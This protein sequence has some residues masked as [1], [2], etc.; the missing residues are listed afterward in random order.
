M[1]PRSRISGVSLKYLV[2]VNLQV[3]LSRTLKYLDK[4]KQLELVMRYFLVDKTRIFPSR[5]KTNEISLIESIR[6]SNAEKTK[7][8][9]P[10]IQ[11]IQSSD[12]FVFRVSHLIKPLL[13]YNTGTISI[14]LK[15]WNICS[16]SIKY[17]I[18]WIWIYNWITSA[19][20]SV[21]FKFIY[22]AF[23]TDKLV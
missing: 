19:H 9:Y 17:C 6:F 2:Q 12:N 10:S 14:A 4:V 20:I 5:K 11:S 8:Q 1:R 18:E 16:N 3:S 22:I 23:T 7:E 13:A 15:W 21:S